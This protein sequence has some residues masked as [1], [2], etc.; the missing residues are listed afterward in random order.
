MQRK[1]KIIISGL[2]LLIILIVVVYL[3]I[4]QNNSEISK[5]PPQITNVVL[6]KVSY[7]EMIQTESLTGDIL[8]IQ[9]ANIY[10]KVS[11]NIE[12]VYVN[13]GDFV[14]DG[15]ILALID[16]TIYSQ[17][18]NLAN[19]NY[20]Q[21]LANFANAKLNYERN[22]SLLEQN[23]ISKQEADNSK[24]SFDV[25]QSQKDAAYANYLNA[26]TLLSYCKIKAPF[27]GYITKR[28]FDAG[29]YVASS[30][31]SPGSTL[32]ILMSSDQLKAIVNLPEKDVRLLP[33]VQD[34]LV[35]ADALPGEQFKAKI[36]KVSEAVDLSTRTMQIEIFI[37]NPNKEL[38]PGMF[39]NIEIIL[40]RKNNVMIL[41]NDVVQSDEKGNFVFVV[42]SDSSAHKSYVET[43]ISHDNKYEIK[44]GI[45]E[46]DRIVITGQQL[47]K[48]GSK[49][50]IIK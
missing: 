12:M 9:Q 30:A 40:D 8:P 33:K 25:A 34:I 32:F 29:V 49:V 21:Q 47:V 15:Q 43:G 14:K 4:R 11:G 42:K 13:I 19:A 36:N 46:S 31:N 50:R 1:K 35:S 27:S 17:N 16:T 24:T 2:V 7:G 5:R 45:S 10:S 3:R 22:K 38:K 44:S 26:K 37:E 23:L 48:D 6:G 28:Y 41:P 18:A 39:A 20:N